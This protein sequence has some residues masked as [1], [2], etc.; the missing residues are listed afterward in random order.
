MLSRRQYA[1]TVTTI[2]VHQLASQLV[3]GVQ[4][5]DQTA[6]RY[7]IVAIS[8]RCDCIL[9]REPDAKSSVHKQQ[10]SIHVPGVIDQH[11]V[12]AEMSYQGGFWVRLNAVVQSCSVGV[13][14][15]VQCGGLP[16]LD[17]LAEM[18]HRDWIPALSAFTTRI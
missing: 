16:L 15:G 2:E 17:C 18:L 4:P 12:L 7:D 5:T 3:G 10:L 11:H 13:G 1:R 8:F 14:I 6:I 9:L